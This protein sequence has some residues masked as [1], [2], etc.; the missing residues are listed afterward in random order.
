MSTR[1]FL[2]T[3][4]FLPLLLLSQIAQ[5]PSFSQGSQ[6]SKEQKLALLS[7]PSVVRIFSG[8][9]A[10]FDTSDL[11]IGT[12]HDFSIIEIGTGFFINSDGYILTNAHVIE[13]SQGGETSC[14]Q[15]LEQQLILHL[16]QN[17]P[18]V[19]SSFDDNGIIRKSDREALVYYQD[20]I[21]INSDTET[22]SIFPF[23]IKES[24]TTRPGSGKDVAVIK[25]Q[26]TDTPVLRI[27][28]SND[29]SLQDE[30]L[31][32]GYP[33]G[34]DNLDSFDLDSILEASVTDGEISS[35]NK[36][37]KDNSLV[38]QVD[39]SVAE[40]SSGSPVL[41]SEGEVVG[42]ITFGN[43]DKSGIVP[44]AVRR[45]VLLE[46]SRQAG[47]SNEKGRVDRLYEQGLEF[48][49]KGDY[50]GAKT[51]FGAVQGLF[52]QHSEIGRLINKSEQGHA[53]Q[54][55]NPD[56]KIWLGGVIAAVAAITGFYWFNK[57]QS[58]LPPMA[59]TANLVPDY[60]IESLPDE[61]NSYS[62]GAIPPASARKGQPI[63]QATIVEG[64]PYIELK[65][66][67]GDKRYLYL[68]G[69]T[70][71][72]GRDAEWSDIEIPDV[73]WEVLSRRHVT[74]RRDGLAYRILDGDQGKPSS[75]G[76]FL[77]ENKVDSQTGYLLKDGDKIL[78]G[79]DSR[80]QIEL[81]YYGADQR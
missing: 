39:V 50:D 19:A 49:W 51:K 9:S 52:P 61:H 54:W 34:G 31:V 7:K 70:H 11:G 27:D 40:G 10:S 29:M 32:I 58:S 42:M 79:G 41:N 23:D 56:Y 46:F 72:I 60:S 76:V 65:N 1:A 22:S 64:D 3:L 43:S 45:D 55:D 78:I 6:P 37:L 30:V 25:V 62:Q 18:E 80:S 16:K 73:G 63:R 47:I 69:D 20:V 44:F 24:G 74:I 71:R 17:Y 5:A 35:V 13:G 36:R 4:A 77:N 21:L 57:K 8:C 75:N 14:I 26:L 15:K 33:A 66:K 59:T 28:E 2:S 81:T 67:Q 12:L 38:L 68:T 48:Y 53:D